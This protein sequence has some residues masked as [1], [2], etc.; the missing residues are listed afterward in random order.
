MHYTEVTKLLVPMDS[1]VFPVNILLVTCPSLLP[2]F[3][4]TGGQFLSNSSLFILTCIYSCVSR[5]LK[6]CLSVPLGMIPHKTKRGAEAMNRLKVFDG[7]PHPYDKV[8]YI[9]SDASD[10]Q[11]SL[12]SDTSYSYLLLS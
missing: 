8:S 10:S 12:L 11:S 6:C 1:L 4:R 9:M 3:L 7:V 2:G 5:S